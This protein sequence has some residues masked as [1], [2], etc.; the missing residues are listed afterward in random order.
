MFFSQRNFPIFFNHFKLHVTKKIEILL[1]TKKTF[2]P[3]ENKNI[4]FD[5][6]PYFPSRIYSKTFCR[7]PSG[8]SE[9]SIIVLTERAI[10]TALILCTVA[11]STIL[12]YVTDLYIILRPKPKAQRLWY[13]EEQSCEYK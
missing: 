1:F 6:S 8:C 3:R 7:D 10:C 2:S 5:Y 13:D 11:A 4:R 12:L 9:I